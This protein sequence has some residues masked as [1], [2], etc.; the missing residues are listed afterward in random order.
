M[1]TQS[2]SNYEEEYDQR[3]YHLTLY[4]LQYVESHQFDLAD[5]SDLIGKLEGLLAVLKRPDSTWAAAFYEWWSI[6]RRIALWQAKRY[7]AQ[8]AV[9]GRFTTDDARLKL[10]RLYPSLNGG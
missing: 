6:L 1:T 10:N 7:H 5:L 8:T 4:F 2:R 9:I 3:Q